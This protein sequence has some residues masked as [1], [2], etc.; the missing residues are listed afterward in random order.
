MDLPL[1]DDYQHLFVSDTP[2]LDV[3]APVEFSQGAFPHAENLPLLNDE[4]RRVIGIR[5]KEMGQDKAIELGHTLVSG[6][7][8]E[9][10]VT[11]WTEFALQHPQGALYCFRGGM[12]SKI[13]Q[14]WIAEKSGVAYP[15]VKGGY[16]A[17]RRFLLNELESAARRVHILVLSG[18][19]GVGKTLLLDQLRAKVDLESL[20]HHRGSAFGKR[21]TPQPSQI[22]VENRL[23]IA[24]LKHRVGNINTL[25]ME[26]EAANIG[27][28]RLPQ[29][30]VLTMQKAPL[31]LLEA[32]ITERV[33]IVYNEYIV[34]ALAEYRK[35]LN[36]SEEF[37]VWSTNLQ[38]ALEKIQR[39]LGGQRHQTI[40]AV[41][42][43]A[44]A[45]H[46]NTGESA[47]HKTWIRHLLEEYYD[48]MYDYQLAKKSERVVYRGSR[49]AVLDYL[50]RCHDIQ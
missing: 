29:G 24:L 15:R 14:Q 41:M 46:C 21:A 3:R 19:T 35:I 45:L 22:D 33:E 30:I 12:R 17:L 27:S 38:T 32:D 4:E 2:L 34:E 8:K 39:R 44:I 9:H 48:P 37:T 5:Y 25:V 43:D 42:D 47:Y 26:D 49:D 36:P 28:R 13:C 11:Q 1:I 6:E 16:K 31:I 7:I 23:A 40:K 20:Y 10:R 50:A 18:R